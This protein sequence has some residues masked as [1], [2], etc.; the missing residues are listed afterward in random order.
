MLRCDL[1]HLTH[2]TEVNVSIFRV[3]KPD[4]LVAV[5]DSPPSKMLGFIAPLEVFPIRCGHS[6]PQNKFSLTS[7]EALCILLFNVQVLN[8]VL[9]SRRDPRGMPS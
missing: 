8:Q 3:L 9:L 5:I 4:G 7:T 1:H 6:I 2:R